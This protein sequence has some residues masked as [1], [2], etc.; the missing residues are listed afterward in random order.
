MREHFEA[1]LF[2]SVLE[3]REQVDIVKSPTTQANAIESAGLP[4]ELCEVVK[5]KHQSI[6]KTLADRGNRSFIFE[7]TD[8][9]L[10]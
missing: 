9:C 4:Q 3:T 5:S 2:E 1:I 6:V 10:K 8:N 7:I